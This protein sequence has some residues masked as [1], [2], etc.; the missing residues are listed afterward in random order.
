[1]L[2]HVFFALLFLCSTSFV[3]AEDQRTL[4]VSGEGSAVATPDVAY[5]SVTVATESE[6]VRKAMASNKTSMNN[7]LA[8]LAK[9]GVLDKDICTNSFTLSSKYKYSKDEE[10]KVVGYVVKN[11]LKITVRDLNKVGVLLDS[12]TTDGRINAVSGVVFDVA[13]KTKV[14]DEA[15]TQAVK[16]AL[17]RAK[18]IAEASGVKLGKILTINEGRVQYPSYS[19]IRSAVAESAYL[20]K[21]EQSYQV[22]VGLVIQLED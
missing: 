5:V 17:K 15:R 6:T 19:N 13:N 16:D 7:V 14:T 9:E 8:V 20:S 10:P 18:L 21:G 4:T 12:L 3:L 22:T 1:M 11:D 2:K